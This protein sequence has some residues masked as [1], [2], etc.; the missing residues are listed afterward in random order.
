MKLYKHKYGGIYGLESML[1]PHLADP[2]PSPF[3]SYVHLYPFEFTTLCKPATE[4]FDGR[5]TAISLNEF[6]DI[7]QMY[8]REEY[9]EL[10]TALKEAGQR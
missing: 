10:V 7:V 2:N 3:V 4:F 9:Q 8:S 6:I 5:F 1:A